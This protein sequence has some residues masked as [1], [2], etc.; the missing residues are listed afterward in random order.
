MANKGFQ[1]GEWN[2]YT[3]Q[4]GMWLWNCDSKFTKWQHPAMWYVAL[5][6]HAIEFARWQH[7]VM[8][9]AALESWHSIRQVAA[10]W[11]VAGGSGWHAIEFALTSAILEFYFWF[12]F[13]PHHRSRHVI[14]HQSAKFY[15]NRTTL[16]KKIKPCRFS[17]WR[18]SAILDFMGPIMGSLKSPCTTSYRSSIET[19]AVNSLVFEIIAF[20][21][22]G[23]RR[24]DKQM[25]RTVALS[26]S[27]SRERRLN[28]ARWD[29]IIGH[30]ALNGIT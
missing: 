12:R 22:F 24:T 16:G 6:W 14:L 18:I 30:P 19:I 27:R 28:N 20:L 2:S 26:R 21:H 5:G 10:P 29:V 13:R 17:R 8:W 7:P 4:C 25:D 1:Y 15:L 9:H 23:D 11:R 3:L